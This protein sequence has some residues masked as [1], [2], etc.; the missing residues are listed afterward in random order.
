MSAY[1]R[2]P[3]EAAPETTVAALREVLRSHEI[4][5]YA[6]VDHGRDMRAAG[7]PGFQAWTLVFGSPAAGA[8]LLAVNLAAAVDI[9]LRLAVIATE[10]D[11]CE[12]VLRELRSL[13]GDSSARQLADAFTTTLHTLAVEAGALAAAGS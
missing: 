12:I 11:R 6:V 4:T 13:L 1:A 5:E 9:P 7:A 2:V 3:V 8:K 10:P